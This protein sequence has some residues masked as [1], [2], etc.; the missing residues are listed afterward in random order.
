MQR[1][2]ERILRG[3]FATAVFFL[4]GAPLIAQD[5]NWDVYGG[6]QYAR[7]HPMAFD[8]P[9]EPFVNGPAWNLAVSRAVGN[10]LGIKAD[11][12]RTALYDTEGDPQ[13]HTAVSLLTYA[14]GPV[15]YRH[16]LASRN[17]GFERPGSK[18]LFGEVLFGGYRQATK[19]TELA[20][21]PIAG[22]ALMVGGGL[23]VSV[24]R[25]IAIRAFDCDWLAFLTDNAVYVHPVAGPKGNL[26]LS[27]G[28]IFRF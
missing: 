10:W 15:F 8:E 26:R 18:I 13:D 3:F 23:D 27:A 21:H 16:R 17:G 6:L 24:S 9:V 5:Q 28:L 11:V 2:A 25:R 19:Y 7:F 12:S 14:F 1:A 22:L 20:G 4:L